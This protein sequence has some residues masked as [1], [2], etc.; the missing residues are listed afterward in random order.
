MPRKATSIPPG[1]R[2]VP[3]YKQLLAGLQ[4]IV[5]GARH[6]TREI[7]ASFPVEGLPWNFEGTRDSA[8]GICIVLNA[9]A[10]LDR[11]L[12]PLMLPFDATLYELVCL[13][14]DDSRPEKFL[15]A[16]MVEPLRGTPFRDDDCATRYALAAWKGDRS[17][18]IEYVKSAE[19]M[20]HIPP[21][22]DRELRAVRLAHD[23]LLR[24]YQWGRRVAGAIEF[25]PW[26]WPDVPP[27][28]QSH[29]QLLD[30]AATK[31]GQLVAAEQDRVDGLMSL[32]GTASADRR[33]KNRTEREILSLCRKAAH[34]GE[35]IAH[36]LGLT[37][38]YTRHV[39][40][41]LRKAERLRMTQDGYRTV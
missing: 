9:A 39:L 23:R 31:L 15:P 34:T 8:G 26:C 21:Q 33:G 36:H 7:R 17:A 3:E 19:A 28:P 35:R 25:L 30:E 1:L 24:H 12:Y 2:W 40:A 20:R 37:Y 10:H 32:A 5:E 38:D 16:D 22:L 11:L 6:L 13:L 4:R 29:L 18:V 41:R 14:S 27:A